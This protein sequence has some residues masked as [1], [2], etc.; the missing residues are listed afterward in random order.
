MNNRFSINGDNA[1]PHAILWQSYSVEEVALIAARCEG[2]THQKRV[3]EALKLIEAVENIA[4]P[5]AAWLDQDSHREE[6]DGLG[7]VPDIEKEQELSKLYQQT[8]EIIRLATDADGK[9]NRIELCNLACEKAGRKSPKTKKQPEEKPLSGDRVEKLFLREWLPQ[10]AES[11]A[12]WEL[13]RQMKHDDAQAR[14]DLRSAI[15]QGSNKKVIAKLKEKVAAADARSFSEEIDRKRETLTDAERKAE[16]EQF[17]LSL[18]Q[19][20]KNDPRIV[21]TEGHARAILLGTAEF[22]GFLWFL[23]YP[24]AKPKYEP[25]PPQLRDSGGKYAELERDAE[26]KIM[27]KLDVSR[28]DESPMPAVQHGAD[29]DTEKKVWKKK[30]Q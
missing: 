13:F 6:G 23:T 20:T 19:G 3:I 1:L 30:P 10:A 7:N 25:R 4:N 27:S 15:E 9:I 26:G 17:R 11:F 8:D 18:E 16:R 24:K 29:N 22:T 12:R 21:H 5:L 28:A 14:E 2:E